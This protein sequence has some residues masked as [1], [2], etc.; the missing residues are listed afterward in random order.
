MDDQ[1]RIESLTKTIDNLKRETAQ[2]KDTI[3]RQNLELQ[4]LRVLLG[5]RQR[6]QIEKQRIDTAMMKFAQRE[7]SFKP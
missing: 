5:Q 1:A 2:L 7:N 4:R 3:A 6:A